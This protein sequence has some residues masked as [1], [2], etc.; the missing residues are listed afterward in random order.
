M[1]QIDSET[2]DLGIDVITDFTKLNT[3]YTKENHLK[4][5]ENKCLHN[6][7]QCKLWL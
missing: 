1:I 2:V 3:F 4:Q 6:Q 5:R 7:G